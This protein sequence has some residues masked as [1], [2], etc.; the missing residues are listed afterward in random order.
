LVGFVVVSLQYTLSGTTY[1]KDLEI[2]AANFVGFEIETKLHKGLNGAFVEAPVGYRRKMTIQF[3]PL[4]LTKENVFWLHGFA[5]GTQREVQFESILPDFV[6]MPG[7]WMTFDYFEK[8]FFANSWTVSLVE[9]TLRT[10]TDTGSTRILK[11]TYTPMSSDSLVG[12]TLTRYVDFVDECSIGVVKKD[13]RFLNGNPDDIP[14]ALWHKF[15]IDFG[16]VEADRFDWLI[17][18]CLWGLKQL[19]TTLLDPD[20]GKV[21]DIVFADKQIQFEFGDNIHKAT[22]LKLT[23]YE[24][25]PRT[26]PEPF[27]PPAGPTTFILDESKLDGGDLLG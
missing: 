25:L 6:A 13:L 8:T 21:F 7:E 11:P 3:A 27:V 15:D 1:N 16:Y 4:G 18:F 23:F 14:F 20:D 10:I 12:E 5:V 17:E 24:R 26:T 2:L 19:D 22:T 9:K